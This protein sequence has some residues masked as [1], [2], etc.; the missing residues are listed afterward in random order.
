[1]YASLNWVNIGSGNGLL[2]V[3]RRAITST[4]VGR[5][6][7]APLGTTLNEF[8]IEYKVLHSWTCTSKYRLRKC[9]YLVPDVCVC[10]CLWGGGGGG[11]IIH[12]L[13]RHIWP[14]DLWTSPHWLGVTRHAHV[15]NLT[16][17]VQL[18]AQG[19]L[20]CPQLPVI[21]TIYNHSPH[22][23]DHH[24]FIRLDTLSNF[25]KCAYLFGNTWRVIT[26]NKICLAMWLYNRSVHLKIEL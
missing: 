20:V 17:I 19:I 9:T 8:G 18:L 2:S 16:G 23:Y 13:F 6:L 7:V 5:S 10:V 24:D 15:V 21:H 1:M 3:Q 14:I 26:L 11:T 22:W 12:Q 25:N 4:N